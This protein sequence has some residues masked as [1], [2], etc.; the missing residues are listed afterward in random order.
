MRTLPFSGLKFNLL[1]SQ[2]EFLDSFPANKRGT[3][4]Q[5]AVNYVNPQWIDI[6]KD[7]TAMFTG[8]EQPT[9]VLKNIDDRRT[10][11]AK[12]AKDPAWK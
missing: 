1:P 8:S 10:Q 3:V 2:Q 4:Y 6:G 11:M 5:T 9:D 7:L 12:A